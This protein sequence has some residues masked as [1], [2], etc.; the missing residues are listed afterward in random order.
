MEMWQFVDKWLVGTSL[1]QWII[2]NVRQKLQA[3][4][5]VNVK[6]IEMLNTIVR[7]THACIVHQIVVE[8]REAGHRTGTWTKYIKHVNHHNSSCWLW[9]RHRPA[10]IEERKKSNL[11]MSNGLCAPH[12]IGDCERVRIIKITRKNGARTRRADPNQNF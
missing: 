2:H 8:R 1:S 11:K 6:I 4:N 12:G 9:E 10:Q 5:V 3:I 7:G